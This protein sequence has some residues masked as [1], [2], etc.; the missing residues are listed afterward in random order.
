MNSKLFSQ[1]LADRICKIW[2]RTICMDVHV[3]F[4]WFYSYGFLGLTLKKLFRGYGGRDINSCISIIEHEAAVIMVWMECFHTSC[5]GDLSLYTQ[6]SFSVSPQE[7]IC[8]GLLKF[9]YSDGLN[10]FSENIAVQS[11]STVGELLPDLITTFLPHEC[12]LAA[13]DGNQPSSV[14][15]VQGL[16]ESCCLLLLE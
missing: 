14:S 6:Y 11:K 13:V 15:I 10:S 7:D 1:F 16:G 3:I 5:Y 12:Q 4:F 9:H 2:D 8:S